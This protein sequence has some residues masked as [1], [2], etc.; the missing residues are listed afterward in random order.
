MREGTCASRAIFEVK[1][2][3]YF[4]CCLR[5]L[6]YFTSLRRLAG[7]LDSPM[8]SPM[9][10]AGRPDST[11]SSHHPMVCEGGR[12]NTAFGEP[13]GEEQGMES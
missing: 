6:T 7:Q 10:R 8:S 12:A 11:L 1:A 5:L 3:R 2:R 4:I 9:V 13:V